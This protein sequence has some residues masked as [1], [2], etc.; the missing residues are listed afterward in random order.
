MIF[1]RVDPA[2]VSSSCFEARRSST[3]GSPTLDRLILSG[4]SCQDGS[5]EKVWADWVCACHA[6]KVVLKNLPRP[7]ARPIYTAE[8]CKHALATMWPKVKCYISN[9]F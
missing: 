4:T 9:S 2:S 8:S 1:A 5:R 3:R 7:I 6:S